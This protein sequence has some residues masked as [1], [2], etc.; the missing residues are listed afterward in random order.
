MIK[1]A[2]FG[3]IYVA[4]RKE[5]YVAEAFMSANSVKDLV[6]DMPITL[7]T[8]LPKCVFAKDTCF[9]NV[10][11]ISTKRNYRMLWAEGQ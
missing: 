9:D 6:P 8:D 10:I 3:M 5:H 4:T 2:K 7:F 11:P 1:K